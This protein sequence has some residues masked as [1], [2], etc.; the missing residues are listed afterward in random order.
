MQVN[1]C[2]NDETKED[3]IQKFSIVFDEKIGKINGKYKIILEENNYP[4]KHCQRSVAVALQ[5]KVNKKLNSLEEKGIIQKNIRTN[6]VD[7]LNGNSGEKNNDIR[8]CLDP[9]DLNKYIKREHYPLPII[10]EITPRLT[11]TKYVTVLDVRKS[12]WHIELEEES[13]K[14]TTFNTPYGRYCWT[15]LPFGICSAT[16]VFQRKM[17]ELIEGL[18]GTE[19]IADAFLILGRGNNEVEASRDNDRNLNAFLEVCRKNNIK[20]NGEKIKWKQ[21]SVQY[22]GYST[23]SLGLLPGDGQIS[24]IINMPVPTA[25]TAVIRFLGMIQYLEKFL[26]RLSE[27]TKILMR[28]TEKKISWQWTE[29]ERKEFKELKELVTSAKILTYYNVKEDICIQCD[30]SQYG[31]GAMIMQKGKAIAYAS[32]TINSTQKKYV[33]IE[34]E[35][36]AIVFACDKFDYY[37]YGKNKVTILSDHKPLQ[38]LYKIPINEIPIRLQKMMLILQR[39]DLNIIYTPVKEMYIADTLSRTPEEIMDINR[40][41]MIVTNAKL[42]VSPEIL[43]R[44]QKEIK[45][46]ITCNKIK[47]LNKSNKC[48]KQNKMDH[49]MKEFYSIRNSI[50]EVDALLYKDNLL[51]IQ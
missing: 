41:D 23:T 40:V 11:N 47:E 22:I 6:R 3:I 24:A 37:I 16:E 33:Q 35:L 4:V 30:T 1:I 44:L 48:P 27:H 31:L 42:A 9:K 29:A 2:S 8:I 12:F 51:M 45:D 36:L 10:E 17:V 21:K 46:D 28:Q 5:E 14:L 13:K 38:T 7:I 15:R 18:N 32:K 20:L 25:I 49:T 26:P 39:Y 19:V 34:K 43:K 50:T